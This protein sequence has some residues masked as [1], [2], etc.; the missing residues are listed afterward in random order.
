[1]M[2]LQEVFWGGRFGVVTDRYGFSWMLSVT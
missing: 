1:M 2:P